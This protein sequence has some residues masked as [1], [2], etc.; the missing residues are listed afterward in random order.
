MPATATSTRRRCMRTRRRSARRS[1]PRHAARRNL[2]DHEGLVERPRRRPLQR[3][4]EASLKRLGVDQVDLLLIHWPSRRIPIRRADRSPSAMRSGAASPAI[5]ASRIFRRRYRRAGRRRSPTSRSSPTRSSTIPGSTRARSSRPARRHG[6]SITSYARSARRGCSTIRSSWRSR[7]RRGR[8]PAQIVLRW[9]IQ[10]PMNIAIPS[11]SNPQRIAENIRHLR[12]RADAGGDAPHLR[13]RRDGRMVHGAIRRL[14]RRLGAAA[15]P[16]ATCDVVAAACA[17]AGLARSHDAPPV[18]RVSAGRHEFHA[19]GLAAG[20]HCSRALWRSRCSSRSSRSAAPRSS[21]SCRSRPTTC[22]RT[23]RAS[24]S[25]ISSSA[26]FGMCATLCAPILFQRLPRRYVYTGR[27]AAP[28]RGVRALR[29]AH[30]RRAGGRPVP[31]HPRREHARDHAQPLHHGVH[32]EAR[33]GAQRVAAADA[34]APSPGRSGR[35]SA[36]GSMCSFGYRRA[37]PLERRLGAHPD[38]ALLVAAP[39]GQHG[40]PARASSGPSIRSPT[41]GASSRSRACGSPGSSPSAAPATG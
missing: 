11:S 28:H 40:D 21:A 17:R 9:H 13:S 25:S 8:R 35:A 32:P 6:I 5:S 36:S 33:A 26:R 31:P 22:C 24:A 29:D 15:D 20:C 27:R 14:G 10:Q 38:R 37:V 39:L 3:S 34:R 23:S 19:A 2:H 16:F 7:A 30:A 18:L 41:S 4:A 12:F 1:A